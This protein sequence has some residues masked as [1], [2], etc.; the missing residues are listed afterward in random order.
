M[1]R[2]SADTLLRRQQA[3]DL[4]AQGMTLNQIRDELDPVG[5]TTVGEW[6]RSPRP[7][8]EDVAAARARISFADQINLKLRF[9]PDLYADF[10]AEAKRQG[11][12]LNRVAGCA[13]RL[14]LE[15][16]A[17]ARTGGTEPVDLLGYRA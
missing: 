14:Y 8:D 6:L 2:V 1:I 10:Q 5:R 13:L 15:C 7:T 4:R 17:R 9:D 11:T 3:H 12:S 16:T